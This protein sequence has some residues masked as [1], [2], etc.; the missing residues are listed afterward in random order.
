MNLWIQFHT[1]TQIPILVSQHTIFLLVFI[2]K[3][4]EKNK[5][6]QRDF[7]AS[8]TSLLVL[9]AEVHTLAAGLGSALH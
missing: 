9:P 6:A 1:V 7:K 3:H 8:V 2:C 4:K 5:P